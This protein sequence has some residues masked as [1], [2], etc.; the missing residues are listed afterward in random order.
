MI[1]LNYKLYNRQ[2]SEIWLKGCC[3]LPVLEIDTRIQNICKQ[4]VSMSFTACW[5]GTVMNPILL[6]FYLFF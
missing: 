3:Y 2:W 5:N 4:G 1:W 6:A